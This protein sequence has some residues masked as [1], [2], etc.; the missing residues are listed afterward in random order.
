[1]EKIS[2]TLG[3]YSPLKDMFSLVVMPLESATT[4]KPRNPGAYFLFLENNHPVG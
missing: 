3:A 4:S 2:L 1:M